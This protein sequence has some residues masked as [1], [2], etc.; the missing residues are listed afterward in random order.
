MICWLG[1]EV[2]LVTTA[3]HTVD[4]SGVGGLATAAPAWLGTNTTDTCEPGATSGGNCPDFSDNAASA[5][6]AGETRRAHR[7]RGQ[8]RTGG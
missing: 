7:V 5:C 4:W 1:G 3:G 2:T 8:Q 6:P